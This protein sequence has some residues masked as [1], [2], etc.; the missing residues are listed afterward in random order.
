[1][2]QLFS[3]LLICFLYILVNSPIMS[4]TVV[5]EVGRTVEVPDN[6]KR[7]IALA[8]SVTEIVYEV[9]KGHHLVGVTRFSDYP[10]EANYLP[11]VG[12][13][14]HL[15]LEK[16]VALEPDLC[17]GIK[18][19]NTYSVVKRLEQFNIPVYAINPQNLDSV[20]TSIGNI[21]TLLGQGKRA[22]ELVGRM[23][24]RIL[25]IKNRLDSVQKRPGVFFQIGIKPI[26]SVGTRTFIHDLI[27]T[28][29]GRNL[30]S[31]SI[32]YPRYSREQVLELKPE[33]IVI[34]SMAREAAFEEE[35]RKWSQW[36]DIPAV[37]H[38]RISIVDSN[39]FD[40]PTSRLVTG[41]EILAHLFHPELF[42]ST[43]Q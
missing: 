37:K 20:M 3:V 4:K 32:P 31:G 40:R 24:Q 16:I 38:N 1:M 14:V 25:R 5:D 39:L 26:V 33:L 27:V 8:P 10:E 29:G 43:E 15:D 17:I 6:P 28:A 22:E 18:D 30:T 7:I 23:E 12:S 2:K 41:L 11:K 13:Y 9:G 19:G 21:G 36:S 35:K 34:S 42:P